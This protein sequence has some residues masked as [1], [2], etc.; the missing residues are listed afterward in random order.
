MKVA[1]IHDAPTPPP[2]A[3][4]LLIALMK[5]GSETLYLRISKLSS[6]VGKKESWVGYGRSGKLSFDAGILRGIGFISSYEMLLRRV[7]VLKHL[8]MLG[9]KIVNPTDSVLLARDKFASILRLKSRGLPVPETVVVE[10]VFEAVEIVK[11]WGKAVIKP[12][13]GSMG[14][15]SI[16]TSDP[17]IVYVVAKMWLT[18]G[19]PLYIQKFERERNR[20]MRILTVDGE[21]LGGIYRYA[22]SSSW[23]TNI[24]QGGKPV[25]FKVGEELRELAIKATEALGLIYSGVDIGE[26]RDGYVIYEVNSAPQWTGFMQ[27]TGINPAEKVA[28]CVV[29]MVRK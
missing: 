25:S 2:S 14:Y 13:V 3:R 26:T 12:I 17:D 23:K 10:D 16:M 29:R 18:H 5:R 6:H 24:S 8:E 11:A 4:Q 20:D 28:E 22:P 9:V 27:A 7:N 19:Q 15:G 21:V 1:I